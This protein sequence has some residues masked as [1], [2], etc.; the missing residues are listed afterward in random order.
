MRTLLVSVALLAIGAMPAKADRPVTDAERAKL[1]VAVVAQGCTGGK[2]EWDEDD[3]G[4][5]VEDAVCNDGRKYEL[6]ST[7]NFYSGA[8]RL[9]T[10]Y[11]FARGLGDATQKQQRQI[12][13]ACCCFGRRVVDYT[14]PDLVPIGTAAAYCAAA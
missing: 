8:R 3:R 13:S 11:R 14:S 7:R 2:M 6:N 10:D 5:E 9:T 1:I 4:F 12:S